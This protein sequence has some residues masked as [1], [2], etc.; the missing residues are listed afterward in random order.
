ML[1]AIVRQSVLYLIKNINFYFLLIFVYSFCIDV[2]SNFIICSFIRTN[3]IFA[4][5]GGFIL[6]FILTFISLYLV[7]YYSNFTR[8]I[9]NADWLVFLY[10][11]MYTLGLSPLFLV[12]YLFDF[13]LFYVF[14][15]FNAYKNSLVF[16]VFFE[17]FSGFF[18]SNYWY[19]LFKRHSYYGYF[20]SMRQR[21]GEIK[22]EEFNRLKY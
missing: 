5:F 6:Y 21:W 14:R 8:S 7:V 20:R 2:R 18:K 3:I 4:S 9:V 19:P 17:L 11:T 12:S 10:R 16:V 1:F 13:V 15:F 22:T